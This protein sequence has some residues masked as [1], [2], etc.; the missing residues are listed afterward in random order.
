MP[1]HKVVR[2]WKFM[3]SV[4]DDW[5]RLGGVVESEAP[6]KESRKEGSNK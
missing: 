4:L 1:A 6:A 3:A 2:L 5:I